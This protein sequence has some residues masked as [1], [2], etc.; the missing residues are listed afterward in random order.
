MKGDLYTRG[1]EFVS[2]PWY[3]IIFTF[4]VPWV[5]YDQLK[6]VSPIF[7]WPGTL[8]TSNYSQKRMPKCTQNKFYC[9][10]FYC[11]C[12][13]FILKTKL[14]WFDCCIIRIIKFQWK[15]LDPTMTMAFSTKSLN[16]DVTLVTYYVHLPPYIH[17]YLLLHTIYMM[18]KQPIKNWDTVGSDVASNIRGLRFETRHCHFKIDWKLFWKDENKD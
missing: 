1:R 14:L 10:L 18:C 12:S 5:V 4:I 13:G 11:I 6:V 2:Q 7:Q 15:I 9:I 16:V 17:T 8:I 3:L